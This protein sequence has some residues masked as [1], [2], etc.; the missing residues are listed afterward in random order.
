M[1]LFFDKLYGNTEKKKNLTAAAAN[2]QTFILSLQSHTGNAANYDQSYLL[3]LIMFKSKI[4]LWVYAR[5]LNHLH[6]QNRSEVLFLT[7]YDNC[8]EEA[9]YQ[10]QAKNLFPLMNRSWHVVAF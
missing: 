2:R 7:C 4:M 5:K 1:D 10:C 6:Q 3:L 9:P 8:S